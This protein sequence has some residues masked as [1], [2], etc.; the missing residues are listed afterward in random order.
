MEIS[1]KKA[2]EQ[3]HQQRLALTNISSNKESHAL[4]SL[5]KKQEQQQQQ[6]LKQLESEEILR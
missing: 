4:Q 1:L 6:L 5:K 3:A 2:T